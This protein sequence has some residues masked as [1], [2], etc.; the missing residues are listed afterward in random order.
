MDFKLLKDYNKE[1]YV[2]LTINMSL[3][4][5]FYYLNFKV[6]IELIPVFTFIISY[7]VSS[8]SPLIF[9]NILS[10]NLKFKLVGY[11]KLPSYSIFSDLVN[12][13]IKE[14]KINLNLLKYEYGKLPTDEGDQYKLWY[15]IYRKHEYNPR[16][17]PNHRYAVMMRDIVTLNLILIV[18]MF[19]VS[20]LL[21]NCYGFIYWVVIMVLQMVIEIVVCRKLCIKY[22]SSVLIEETYRIRKIYDAKEFTYA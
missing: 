3:Y 1:L 7:L 2:V 12:G 5:I 8:L 20:L 14:E 10:S 22:I 17:F 19:I 15:E 13:K 18:I 16:V 4:I 11:S 9:L 21:I 6:V